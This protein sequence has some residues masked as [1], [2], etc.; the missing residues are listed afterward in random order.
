MFKGEDFVFVEESFSALEDKLLDG[1]ETGC[2]Q[3]SFVVVVVKIV[4]RTMFWTTS[5]DSQLVLIVVFCIVYMSGRRPIIA[6][7]ACVYTH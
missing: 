7:Q 1:R 2:V 6:C 3:K 5:M 4:Q